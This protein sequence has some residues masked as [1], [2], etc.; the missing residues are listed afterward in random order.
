MPSKTE[1]ILKDGTLKLTEY[2]LRHINAD[3]DAFDVHHGDT[4]EE[5]LR[6]GALGDHNGETVALVLEKHVSYHPAWHT[7]DGQDPDTY[8]LIATFGDANALRA[9]GWI[10]PERNDGGMHA[11]CAG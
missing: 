8:T 11:H 5:A 3:G 10:D 4:Q 7:P 9:G 6:Y 2:E 1:R